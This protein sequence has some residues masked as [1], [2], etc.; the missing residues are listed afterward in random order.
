MRRRG[1]REAAAGAATLVVIIAARIFQSVYQLYSNYLMA[2]DHA[3]MAFYGLG[4][5]IV[6][7]LVL[8]V[9]LVPRLGI[10]GA[11]V[12]SLANVLIC[13]T[14]GRF[15]LGK[16][17]PVVLE[18]KPVLHILAA[19]GVM[20]LSLLVLGLVVV[21]DS[22]VTTGL[23]VL[24]GAAIYLGVLLLL[25]KPIRDDALRTLKIQWIPQ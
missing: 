10:T 23:L 1:S 20:T 12:A 8:S 24:T 2:T 15:F 22:A 6:V 17:I 11:A 9:I 3:R 19:T 5:G 16:V 7:N 25:D 4:T 13:V 21:A 14:M 18:R